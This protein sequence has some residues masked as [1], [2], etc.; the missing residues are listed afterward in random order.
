MFQMA[1]G[2]SV[3]VYYLTWQRKR[4]PLFAEVGGLMTLK[5]GQFG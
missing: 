5:I 1:Q 2:F 3:G 4:F